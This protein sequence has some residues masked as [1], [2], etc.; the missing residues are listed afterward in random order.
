[1][2]LRPPRSR[3][4][5]GGKRTDDTANRKKKRVP[6]AISKDTGKKKEKLCNLNPGKKKKRKR[7][8]SQSETRKEITGRQE[9][10]KSF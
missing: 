4:L 8:H 5:D 6:W 9:F 7:K 1:M 10:E 2:V 3:S